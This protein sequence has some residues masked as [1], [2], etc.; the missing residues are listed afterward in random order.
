[1]IHLNCTNCE[2][3]NFETTSYLSNYW[4]AVF[5]VHG[6]SIKQNTIGLINIVSKLCKLFHSFISLL[7]DSINSKAV[8]DVLFLKLSC[9]I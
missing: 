4:V 3:N 2:S 6:Y 1:M 8:R 9:N 7:M 5:L